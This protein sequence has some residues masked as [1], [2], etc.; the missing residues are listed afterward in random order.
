MGQLVLAAKITHVPSM[1]VSEQPGPHQGC[2]AA[3]IA[4]HRE[5]GRRAREAGADTFIV[6]DT[7]WL[8]NSGFH[9]NANPRHR[10]TYTS[11]EFPHFIRELSFDHPGDAELGHAIAEHA[12]K[13]GVPT[14]AHDDVP[15]LGLEYGTLVPMRY[16]NETD[17]LGVVSVAGW[18]YDAS[19]EESRA[20]GEAILDAI[21]ATDRRV[22]LLASG[23]LSHRIWP[24]R[25]VDDGMFEISSPFNGHVDRMVLDLWR[26]GRIGEFLEILPDYA[27][28]CSGE[29]HMHDTAM[30]FGALG[31]DSYH[32]RAEV[33]TDWFPSSGTG[34]CNVVFPVDS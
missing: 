34:Q 5:I 24:N 26:D 17:Q 11:N 32:G 1:F 15:S 22:A 10:G 27:R 20:V 3:A 2:R 33:I 19:F 16:M 9:V 14:R 25:E 6:L 4:G 13:R 21:D 29:G 30:L 18:M 23:S 12:T 28:H 7:H 8:V 31:W